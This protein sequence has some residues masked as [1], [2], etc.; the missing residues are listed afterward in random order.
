MSLPRL[1]RMLLQISIFDIDVI[2][3]NLKVQVADCL[4]HLIKSNKVLQ[5]DSFDSAVH[6]IEFTISS[7]RCLDI[8]DL[9]LQDTTLRKL[10]ENILEGWPDCRSECE[11][12]TEEYYGFKDEIS[13][14]Q[15]MVLK[16]QRV[17]TPKAL[18]PQML[19]T[20]HTGHQGTMKM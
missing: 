20:F 9:T 18:R 13:V 16:G 6:D 10:K 4:C 7:R 5:M 15:G 12:G 19:L 3:I 17:V 8:A 11:A 14:Y 2:Y 1:H